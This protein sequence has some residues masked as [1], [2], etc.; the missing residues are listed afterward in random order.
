MKLTQVLRSITYEVLGGDINKEIVSIVDNSNNVV[1]NSV[2]FALNGT[3]VNGSN[4]ISLAV[5]NGATAVICEQVPISQV[6]GVTYI[7]VDNARKALSRAAMNF[8]LP[9]GYSFKVVGVTGTNGKTTISF[10]IG[11]T[12][13]NAG[14]SVCVVGTSGV[15]VN[16]K[17]IRGESLTTLD[18][19]DNADLFAFLKDIKIDFVVME[20]S[21][22]ALWF[23]KVSAINFD[24]GI[25]TNLTE[26]H[27]DFFKT[28]EQYGKAKAK[29]FNLVKTAIINIDDK[30]G[31]VLSEKVKNVI[32]YGV[33]KEAD[34]NIIN[35]KN[36]SFKLK[37]NNKSNCFKLTMPGD[38]NHY[39]AA[40]AYIVLTG[41]GIKDKIIE[42]SLKHLNKIDGRFNEFKTKNNGLIVL[43]FA[44]TPDGLEKVLTAAQKVKC[45][46]GKVI[47]VFGCGG[48][49]DRE[50]R[51]IMGRVS[52]KLAD[53][54]FI[55]ID[56]PRYEDENVVMAD[57]EKGIKEVTSNYKIVM[58]RSKAILNAIEM[59]ERGDVVVISGKGTEPYYEVN[60]RKQF[61]R[62]DVVIESIIKNLEK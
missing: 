26:D 50:K 35:L 16:G 9:A 20:V 1:K 19:I 22:H 56:N 12:L 36:N 62:E 24:Y 39:N 49:R 28:M 3:N 38:Y 13:M 11:E 6:E 21:S 25:F 15:F 42:N 41:L 48:N 55:S 31:K 61:Y 7:K 47:S 8:Y 10:M 40:A 60:G 5:E 46:N 2:F 45:T 27:L 37:H 57:I 30:F 23:D 32:T 54:T 51:A 17:Q 29:F 53:F 52:G 58:P 44:H 34:F 43:D 33:N 14:K 4:F 59:S 18:P